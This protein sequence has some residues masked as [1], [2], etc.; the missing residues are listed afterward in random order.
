M[1]S[2]EQKLREALEWALQ[3]IDAIPA[4]VVLPAMP[5]FDRD[6]VDGLVQE[7]KEATGDLPVHNSTEFDG[8][9]VEFW[10]NKTR[11]IETESF[12]TRE[13]V[14]A[15]GFCS[16]GEEFPDA[17]TFAED[18]YEIFGHRVGTVKDNQ[19]RLLLNRREEMLDAARDVF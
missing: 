11:R 18:L 15:R 1:S 7:S 4:D 13:S 12:P 14:L 2:R 19:G 16:E 10:D 8:F 6:Y 3:Y 17:E 9:V 5:G